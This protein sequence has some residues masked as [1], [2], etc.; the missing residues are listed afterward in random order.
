MELPK[1]IN[2]KSFDAAEKEFIRQNYQSM[3]DAEIAQKLDRKANGIYRMRKIM[4]L[5][6][7]N[8]R[9]RND[10]RKKLNPDQFDISIDDNSPLRNLTEL[11]RKKLASKIFKS[12]NDYKRFCKQ[13]TE[14]EMKTFTERFSDYLASWEKI[15][16]QEKE[17]LYT[18]MKEVIIQDRLLIKVKASEQIRSILSDLEIKRLKRISKDIKSEE[19]KQ[20]EAQLST[21]IENMKMNLEPVEHMLQD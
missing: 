13:F 1:K 9:P 10:S 4:H 14:D 16:P 18:V 21:T 2:N 6:K 5:P 15:L 12:S 3:T 7:K 17:Q 11:E 8:G 19:D 20:E